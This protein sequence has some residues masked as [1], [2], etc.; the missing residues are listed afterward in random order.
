[1]K[2]SHLFL[3]LLLSI[4]LSSSCNRSVENVEGLPY[5]VEIS[6]MTD[7]LQIRYSEL[8][9]DVKYVIL[10]ADT[11]ESAI[12]DFAHLEITKDNDF[13][14]FDQALKRVLRFDSEGNFLNQIGQNGHAANEYF[15]PSTMTYDP[16]SDL[17]LVNCWGKLLFYH[18][19]GTFD[20][21]IKLKENIIRHLSVLQHK[22][23]IAERSYLFSNDANEDK[24]NFQIYDMEGNFL[25]GF[26]YLPNLGWNGFTLSQS[27][28]FCP[29]DDGG[30]L[31]LSSFSSTMYKVKDGE[32]TPF[33]EF[34]PTWGEWHIGAP[35][36]IKECF[37]NKFETGI[38]WAQLVDDKLYVNVTS[39]RSYYDFLLCYDLKTKQMRVGRYVTNDVN[40]V[41]G[42]Y[43]RLE[44]LKDRKFYFY[45]DSGDFEHILEAWGDKEVKPENKE[46]VTRM[47]NVETPI[48]QICTLKD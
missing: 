5:R 2:K 36:Q 15:E 11:E 45:F 34:V 35:E 43:L 41:V 42:Y 9:S 4:G 7:S 21:S 44:A 32:A 31:C 39:G 27:N 19:D 10:K 30:M 3:S 46:F 14:V 20:H 13:I 26:E 16:V 17:V 48:L 6:N 38:D 29:T 28:Q 24:H 33:V 22:Y 47:S 1:M 8:F 40:G 12:K 18:L 37:K 25:S 23:I